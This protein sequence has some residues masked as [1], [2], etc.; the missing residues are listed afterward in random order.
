[1][2]KPFVQLISIHAFVRKGGEAI[3]LPLLF[4]LITRRQKLDYMT[5]LEAIT[6]GFSSDSKLERVL[7]DFEVALWRAFETCFSSSKINW[8]QFPFH[9]N[10]F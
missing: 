3:Q 7:L 6:T 2:R 1:M 8:L 10:N 9:A 4:C 5:I